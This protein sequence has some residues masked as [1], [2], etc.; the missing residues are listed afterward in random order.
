[1]AATHFL[2]KDRKTALNLGGGMLVSFLQQAIIAGLKAANQEKAVPY[3]SGSE[4]GS[5]ARLSAMMGLGRDEPALTIQPMYQPISGDAYD[6]S[7]GEYY[8][9]PAA[10]GIGEYYANPAAPVGMGEFFESGIEGFGN[11]T[12]N[13][14]IMEAA[15]G[16]GGHQEVT[17]DHIDPSSN[18]DYELSVAE[19]QAGVGSMGQVY[20]AAAGM[21][22]VFQAAAGMGRLGHVSDINTPLEPMAQGPARAYRD[23]SLGAYARGNG[24]PQRLAEAQAGLG[25]YV[26]NDGS[27]IQTLPA[28]STVIPGQADGALWAGVRPVMANAAGDQAILSGD[29]RAMMQTPVTAGIMQTMGGQGIFG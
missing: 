2:V 18:L 10:P 21:G 14:D 1:M 11:Y 19:A 5:A 22:Q 24:V 25:E 26:T 16:L 29:K 15:A 13:P 6:P 4:D 7:M 17:F 27:S 3:L 28:R 12:G 23:G 20:Q 8:A 9:N